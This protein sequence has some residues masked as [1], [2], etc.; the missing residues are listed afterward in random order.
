MPRP[1]RI[2][3]PGGIYHVTG[4]AN[5]R[6]ALF[7]DDAD[8]RTWLSLLDPV[9]G[10]QRWICPPF[11]LLTTHYHLLLTT[12]RADLAAGMQWLNSRYAKRFNRR[13]AEAGHVFGG[14]YG[15]VLVEREEH[16]LELTRYVALNPVR[17]PAGS[18]RSGPGAATRQPAASYAG[19]AS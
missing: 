10:R 18:R 15:S 1:P 19:R 12:P 17:V 14:R 6:A 3:V 13:H 11:C 2:Q 16:L 8:R 9:V 4:R 5:K 7:R